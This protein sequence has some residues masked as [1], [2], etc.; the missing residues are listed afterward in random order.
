MEIKTLQPDESFYSWVRTLVFF[1]SSTAIL[2]GACKRAGIL[3]VP[4]GVKRVKSEGRITALLLS[5]TH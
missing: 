4:L 1:L 3:A 2:K 5:S